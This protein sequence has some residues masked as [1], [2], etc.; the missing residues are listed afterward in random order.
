M[1]HTPQL[2]THTSYDSHQP[3]GITFC[4]SASYFRPEIDVNERERMPPCTFPSVARLLCDSILLYRFNLFSF[5]QPSFLCCRVVACVVVF[6]LFLLFLAIVL[7]LCHLYS[8][9]C[10]A[11]KIWWFGS[12]RD[13]RTSTACTSCNNVSFIA[14]QLKYY[15]A[16]SRV[17]W[18][19]CG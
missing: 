3:H 6:Y 14:N 7:L 13:S 12:L 16:V 17:R 11:P 1:P 10:P 19:G 5:R 15:T 4:F 8:S 9:L 2:H 18:I